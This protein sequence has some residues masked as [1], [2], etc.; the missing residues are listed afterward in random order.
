[1]RIKNLAVIVTTEDNKAYQ[2]ALT[3]EMISV[4]IDDLKS[5]YFPDSNIKVIDKELESIGIVDLKE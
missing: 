3:E 4:L 2:V 5:L 1:M